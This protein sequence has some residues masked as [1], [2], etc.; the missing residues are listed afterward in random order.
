MLPGM[1]YD[2]VL[3]FYFLGR[4]K[5]VKSGVSFGNVFLYVD[6]WI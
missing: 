1:M 4:G 3:F 6:I 5:T 2:V